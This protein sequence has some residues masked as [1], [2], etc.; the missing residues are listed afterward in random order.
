MESNFLGAKI[1]GQKGGATF[2]TPRIFLFFSVGKESQSGYPSLLTCLMSRL[3]RNSPTTLPI[4]ANE[5][6][7]LV[8]LQFFVL[9][10]NM[11]VSQNQTWEFFL[12]PR[13][14]LHRKKSFGAFSSYAQRLNQPPAN[15]PIAKKWQRERQNEEEE[16]EL[17]KSCHRRPPQA[18]I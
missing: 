10:R 7:P 2:F 16:E 14:P 6:F 8:C 3:E 9:T 4:L 15:P 11:A 18:R 12:P 1:R 13:R 5:N 17:G